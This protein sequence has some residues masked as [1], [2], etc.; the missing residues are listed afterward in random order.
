MALSYVVFNRIPWIHWPSESIKPADLRFQ[1]FKK[2]VI[3]FIQGTLC[4]VQ[5]CSICAFV[6][7]GFLGVPFTAGRFVCRCLPRAHN[8]S[9]HRRHANKN[10]GGGWCWQLKASIAL[11][12][13]KERQNHVR[14]GGPLV[15]NPNRLPTERGRLPVPLSGLGLVGSHPK[16]RIN[17]FSFNLVLPSSR[18][19]VFW[20]SQSWSQRDPTHFKM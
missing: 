16:R 14:L 1:M 19:C 9:A 17:P 6:S 18:G 11:R 15:I 2:Q 4:E 5:A 12:K 8:G 3:D 10:A 13:K 7:T 20:P